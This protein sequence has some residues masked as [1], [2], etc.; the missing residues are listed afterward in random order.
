VPG[1]ERRELVRRRHAGVAGIAL[2]ITRSTRMPLARIAR[3]SSSETAVKRC[4]S[5]SSTPRI[6]RL[7]PGRQ[8]RRWQGMHFCQL[9]A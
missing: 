4:T 3:A 9:A 6:A 1:A 2:W 8:R 7:R 5:R